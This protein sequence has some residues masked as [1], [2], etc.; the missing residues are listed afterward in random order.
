MTYST[1]YARVFPGFS[2]LEK[3]GKGWRT[4]VVWRT[5]F[6]HAPFRVLCAEV[7]KSNRQEKPCM[8]N[9]NFDLI[10]ATHEA[11]PNIY[12]RPW[13]SQI[14]WQSDQLL[15]CSRSKCLKDQPA[16]IS[17]LMPC[18]WK[19]KTLFAVKAQYVW[20]LLNFTEKIFLKGAHTSADLAN[21]CKVGV[22]VTKND[23]LQLQVDSRHTP[24]V[25]IQLT[26]HSILPGPCM[27]KLLCPTGA[28]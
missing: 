17:I 19:G 1:L 13:M 25:M 11:L 18:C 6:L 22:I 28:K 24:N 2:F 21:H 20:Y 12:C 27:W 15:F 4:C 5:Q 8:Q 7:K 14:S 23:Q 3:G 9:E 10:I 26:W 16:D